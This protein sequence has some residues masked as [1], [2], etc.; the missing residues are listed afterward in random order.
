F[1]YYTTATFIASVIA[2]AGTFL[3]SFII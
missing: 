3:L 1:K 2:L